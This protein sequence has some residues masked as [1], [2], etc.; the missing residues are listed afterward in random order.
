MSYVERFADELRNRPDTL[1]LYEVARRS[2]VALRIVSGIAKGERIHPEF[3]TVCRIA[4]ALNIS[5]D[6]IVFEE[7]P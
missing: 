2:G 5:L 4:H 7:H 6:E 3:D 1:S